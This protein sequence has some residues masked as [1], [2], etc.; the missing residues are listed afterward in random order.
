MGGMGGTKGPLVFCD[1]IKEKN[2]KINSN[3][4]IIILNSYLYPF[5]QTVRELS[6][7]TVIFQQDN[8]P[9]HTSKITKEWLKTNKIAIIDWPANSPDLNPI[10]NI[11]SLLKDNV[12]SRKVFLRDISELKVALREEWENLDSSVFKKVVA[13]M[14]QRINA[15][16]KAK[17]GS[18][19]Y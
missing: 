13:S 3:T 16:L 1:E 6:E 5:Q 2:E 7:N 4:Y 11:W 8:A 18:I 9:I 12:Q 19:K 15:V 10:E 17:G 14:P